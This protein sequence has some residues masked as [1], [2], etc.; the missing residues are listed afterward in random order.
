MC[1][2]ACLH[3]DLLPFDKERREIVLLTVFEMPS[4]LHVLSLSILLQFFF[5]YEVWYFVLG[6]HKNYGIVSFKILYLCKVR[7]MTFIVPMH[8]NKPNIT[9]LLL[10]YANC[11]GRHIHGMMQ[12][13]RVSVTN[14]LG[15][16]P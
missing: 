14:V 1:Q 10:T 5:E 2:T 8:R 15:L 11:C 12:T 9:Y 3:T 7:Y 13:S 16:R 4:V 6:F